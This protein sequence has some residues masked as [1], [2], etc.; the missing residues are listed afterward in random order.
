MEDQSVERPLLSQGNYSK[1]GTTVNV[2][3]GV[4]TMRLKLAT[5]LKSKSCKTFY[6]EAILADIMYFWYILDAKQGRTVFFTSPP[7]S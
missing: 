5:F 4:K 7:T 6:S 1:T 2:P 3:N